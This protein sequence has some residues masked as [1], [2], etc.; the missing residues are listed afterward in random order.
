MAAD[1]ADWTTPVNIV[2]GSVA[3][4]G[5]ATVQITGTPTVQFAAG[6]SVSISGVPTVQFAAGQSVQI[7]SGTVNIQNAP[8]T[9]VVT[10]QPPDKLATY[11]V[12]A[13]TGGTVN[14]VPPAGCHALGFLTP[15]N[16]AVV[17]LNR[18]TGHTSGD[19]YWTAPG[20]PATALSGTMVVV[21][22][23]F[24]TAVD[25]SLDV[26][27]A[28]SSGAG[29]NVDIVALYDIETLATTASAPLVARVM[30][31]DA[32]NTAITLGI[33]P[34]TTSLP[35]VPAAAPNLQRTG[36]AVA[37]GAT[38]S[39]VAAAAKIRLLS[40]AGNQTASGCAIQ[41]TNGTVLWDMPGQ[42][43]FVLDNPLPP[44]G[45]YIAANAGVNAHNYGGASSTLFITILWDT[46]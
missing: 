3:I 34:A 42:S 29:V 41:D 31:A 5:T 43:P 9:K 44:G 30:L 15:N 28:N 19:L 38:V 17:T 25:A 37:A 2:G 18:I 16:A 35:V 45:Y 11:A 24:A 32:V 8:G 21:P 46:N 14:I 36:V 6:Q 13:T 12:P 39:L 20:S 26:N 1:V 23:A 7:T 27:F 40:V 33:H 22:I 10:N 4:S